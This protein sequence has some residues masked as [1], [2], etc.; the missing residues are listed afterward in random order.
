MRTIATLQ[1]GAQEPSM[2]LEQVFVAWL[3]MALQGSRRL[4]ESLCVSKPG[5]SPMWVVHWALGLGYYTAMSVAVWID[6]SSMFTNMP[7]KS[8]I[9]L[10][11]I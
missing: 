7:K 9:S 10:F 8:K 11:R 2:S 6:G 3:F 1:D 5:S 4:Y